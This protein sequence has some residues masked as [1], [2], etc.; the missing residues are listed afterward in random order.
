MKT[1]VLDIETTGLPPKG[2]TYE[3]DFM[4][5]PYIVTLAFKINEEE[6][7]QYIINQEGRL[8]PPEATAIHGITDEMA[9]ASPHKLGEV[10]SILLMK[11]NA[12]DFV[13]GHNI[14]FDTSTIK[15]NVLRLLNQ[16]SSV[17]PDDNFKALAQNFYQEI[18]TLLHKD[19]RVDTMQKT[20]AFCNIPGPYGNQKKW[21][22]LTELHRKLFDCDFDG[23]HSSKGDVD[24]TYKCYIKLKELGVI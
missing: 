18:E 13:I 1:V 11:A 17:P 10:L 16:E 19:R 6:T 22:K 14:Y 9:N 2:A 7:E 21:P 5:Y 4:Q 12:A 24:A 3:K 8:I 20:I 15:A 23:A